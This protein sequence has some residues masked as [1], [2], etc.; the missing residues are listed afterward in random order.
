[1]TAEA[2]RALASDLDRRRSDSY[3]SLGYSTLGHYF[4][5]SQPLAFLSPQVREQTDGRL[6]ALSINW[7][8]VVVNAIEERLDVEGFRLGGDETADADLWRIWQANDLDEWSQMGHA[9]ALTYGRA[10]SLVWSDP[11]QPDQP[12]VTVESASQMSVRYRPGSRRIEAAAKVFD[13]PESDPNSPTR[14]RI[15][16]LY[17]PDSAQKYRA[18]G[19]AA[20][21]A[22]VWE[23]DGEPLEN[24]LGVVPVSALVNR[25][26]LTNLHGES[27]LTDL[28]PLI[29]AV[30]K[31]GTDMMVS[32]EFHAEPR[33][34]ATGL[35]I[36]KE[37]QTSDR[38]RAQVKA[39]WDDATKG[40]TWLAGPGVEFGQFAEAQ[41][42]NFIAAVRMLEAAI[43]AIG[44]LPPHYMG[45]SGDNPA[46][47]DAIR[48][49]EASLVKTA[50]RKQR[51]FGGGWEQTMRLAVAVRDGVPFADLDPRYDH[52]EVQWRD[53][54]TPTPAEKADAALKLRSADI[55]TGNQAL[56]DLGYSPNQIA[57]MAAERDSAKASEITA[58]VR[59]RVDQA[60]QLMDSQGLSQGAAFAAVG[61]L[62]AAQQISA[63]P[64]SP[65]PAAGAS[66]AA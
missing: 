30:N 37:A 22:A 17:L 66:P 1:M 47:A 25:P 56:E 19:S 50:Q 48:S 46:S 65:T 11:D 26:S 60:Q 18:R 40:K 49:A 63:T 64:G 4:R 44:G 3:G 57:R 29:D 33:R 8:R 28:I 51:T 7:A 5:G 36:P 15:G 54:N 12:R 45:L 2:M 34:Y 20:G 14:G 43:A 21:M 61:L 23:P 32:S 39:E 24:P 55:I 27:E 42:A 9:D 13:D 38:M 31:L 35:Q 53:P 6:Q 10:F 16:W 52:L 59:A 41:L 58:D 62:A